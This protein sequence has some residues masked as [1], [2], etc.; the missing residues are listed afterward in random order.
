MSYRWTI[1]EI[2]E[3]VEQIDELSHELGTGKVV[4]EEGTQLYGRAWRLYRL[5]KHHSLN[6]HE[7][8]N[9]YLG[10]TK[11]E[12]GQALQKIRWHMMDLVEEKESQ[13]CSKC[14]QKVVT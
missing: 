12:A 6:R 3:L 8:F 2:R 9:D 1:A 14:G 10:W 4:L 13:C 7:H 5:G 11:T